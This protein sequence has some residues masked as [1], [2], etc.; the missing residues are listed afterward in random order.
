MRITRALNKAKCSECRKEIYP[1]PDWAYKTGDNVAYLKYQCS[2][3]CHSKAL[4]REEY[5][6]PK[7]RRFIPNGGH[8]GYSLRKNC[9]YKED[10]V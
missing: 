2:Y 6:C 7:C 3:S 5:S 10:I 4:K 8:C 1:T 9:K